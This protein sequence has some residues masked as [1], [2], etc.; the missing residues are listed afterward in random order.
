V[1]SASSIDPGQIA[2]EH[3]PVGVADVALG[4]IVAS[5]SGS[6][7]RNHNGRDLSS[8][9]VSGRQVQPEGGGL[10]AVKSSGSILP[11]H[12][13]GLQLPELLQIS[14][15]SESSLEQSGSGA[16]QPQSQ[17]SFA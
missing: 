17:T 13:L 7:L 3:E 14:Q 2:S 12:A 11:G 4:W 10:H 15:S 5:Q 16:P 1:L 9:Y 8:A 6:T